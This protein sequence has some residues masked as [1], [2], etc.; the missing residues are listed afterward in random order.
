MGIKNII[1]AIDYFLTENRWHR[2][3]VQSFLT[4]EKEK[5]IM[6]LIYQL[7][8]GGAE[9]VAANLAE[10]LGKS[11]PLVL[12]TCAP[13]SEDDY[14]CS[15]KRIVLRNK[16]IL[17]NWY[18]A[19]QI[20]NL[21]KKEKIT[22]TISFCSRMNYLN[23]M[24]RVDDEVII[25]IRNYLSASEKEIKYQRINQI[26]ARYADKITVVS[27]ELVQDQIENFHAD[28]NKIRVIPNFCDGEKIESVLP[29]EKRCAN[30]FPT[31]IN[32]GR[33]TYQKGQ[34]YLIRA[35]RKV[36][37][38]VPEAKLQIIGQGDQY[39]KLAQEIEKLGL[40]H[41]VELMTF[42]KN[43]YRY[44]KSAKVF[45]LSSFYEGFSNVTLEAMFCGL[46]IIATDCKTGTREI[47]APH[48]GQS[49]PCEKIE[50][51]EYG[52]LVPMLQYENAVEILADAIVEVLQNKDLREY[53]AQKSK[54]RIQEFTKEKIMQKWMQLLEE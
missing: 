21:K 30:R 46:P 33:F 42:Q 48:I 49:A 10:E 13:K 17:K 18:L 32:V 39:E 12:V 16:G 41:C 28:A 54:E 34:L 14:A 50:K 20:R 51:M 35:F 36:I 38:Y 37:E 43:P 24:S 29:K 45:V 52:I 26:S 1:K 19:K 4:T 40:S 2:Q 53:Y 9:R 31:I 11:F 25:S 44:M 5:R 47:L 23:C 8:N 22:H 15:A 6:I 3:Q 27:E 7:K